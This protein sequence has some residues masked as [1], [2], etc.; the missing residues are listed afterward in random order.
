M[1]IAA[2]ARLDGGQRRFY[3]QVVE[4]ASAK[5]KRASD[6]VLRLPRDGGK[7]GIAITAVHRFPTEGTKEFRHFT[8]IPACMLQRRAYRCHTRE[9]AMQRIA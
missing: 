9:P 4:S 2:A 3:T 8:A 5:F 7:P 1:P 6:T